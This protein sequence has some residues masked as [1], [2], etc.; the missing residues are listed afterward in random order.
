MYT[1]VCTYIYI[2]IY[3]IHVYTYIYIYILCVYV[4]IYI[5]IYIMYIHICIV[6][7]NVCYGGDVSQLSDI[8]R[9]TVEISFELGGDPDDAIKRHIL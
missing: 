6:K 2:Y 5:Y 9:A 4:C 8:V 3:I 7:A 1:Y